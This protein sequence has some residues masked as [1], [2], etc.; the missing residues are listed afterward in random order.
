MVDLE[1]NLDENEGDNN[2]EDNN[3]ERYTK[4]ENDIYCIEGYDEQQPEENKKKEDE[5]LTGKETPKKEFKK[6]RIILLGEKGVGKS[7]LIERYVNNK[8]SNFGQPEIGDVVKIKKFEIDRYLS[9]ELDINDTSEVENLGKYPKSYYTDA[10]GALLVFSLTDQDS[11]QKMKYWMEQLNS[12]A[13]PDIV[14]CFLGNQSDKT[15]DRKINSDEIKS[16]T[17]DHLFYEVSAKTGI[18]VTLAFEELTN[19]IIEKQKEE[20]KN[21]EKVVRGKEGRKS[22]DLK[23][24]KKEQEKKKKCC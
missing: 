3:D 5:T 4:V 9:V 17:K 12:N 23:D 22:W 2:V 10:H 15:A 21:P 6:F 1:E 19:K 16:L 8:F 11:F 13:P 18:N 24:M 7:S 14:I 20:K